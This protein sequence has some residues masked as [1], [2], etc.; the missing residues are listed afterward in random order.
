MQRYARDFGGLLPVRDNLGD[1]WYEVGD[2]ADLADRSAKVNSNTANLAPLWQ[3]NYLNTKHLAC[4]DNRFAPRQMSAM[5]GDFQAPAQR[6]YSYQN[7][8]GGPVKVADHPQLALLADRNPLIDLRASAD[9]PGRVEFAQDTALELTAPS[10][11]H[12][13]DG[14]NVLVADGNVVWASVGVMSNGDRIWVPDSKPGDTSAYRYTGSDA[15]ARS[16]DS[17]LVP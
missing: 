3:N 15:P 2:A 1:V 11:L 7:Q 9:Q 12:G 14:Q 17:M 8:W 6:S 16:G 13:A 4:P 5:Q 10:L